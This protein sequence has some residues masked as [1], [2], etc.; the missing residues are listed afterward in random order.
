MIVHAH[1]L[2]NELRGWGGIYTKDFKVR[3]TKALEG[4][5]LTNSLI[6]HRKT[7]NERE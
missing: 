4:M 1:E 2:D 5:P 6:A 7:L 3:V